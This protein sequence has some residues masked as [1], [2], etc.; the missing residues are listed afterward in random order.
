LRPKIQFI[1]SLNRYNVIIFFLLFGWMPAILFGQEQQNKDSLD[2]SLEEV[3]VTATRTKRQLSN[4]T[5]PVTIISKTEVQR[6]GAQRLSDLLEEQTGITTIP[7]FG[8]GIGVQLQGL[9]SQYTLILIDGQPL[10]GR[11]AGTLDLNRITVSNIEQIEVLKGASSSLYGNEALGGVINIITSKEV[12]QSSFRFDGRYATFNTSDIGLEFKHRFEDNLSITQSLNRYGSSGYRL[13]DQTTVATVQPF[14][15]YTYQ[16]NASFKKQKHEFQVNNRVFTQHQ[17]DALSNEIDGK[18]ETFEI[19]TLWKY[20]Y[21]PSEK[22]ELHTDLYRSNYKTE[23]LYTFSQS[24]ELYESNT[25]N[26]I[27]LRPEM[28]WISKPSD[29]TEYIV[30]VGYTYETLK[31]D[32]FFKEPIFKAPYILAQV[33]SDL[34][35]NT[36]LI[37]G[38]RFDSHNIY[39]SQLSPKLSFRHKIDPKTTLKGSIGYGFK[40]PDFRQL[41]FDFSNST[42][43]YIVLGHEAVQSRIPELIQSGQILNLLTDLEQFNDPLKAESSLGY[44][45]EISK[46]WSSTFKS[47]FNL[48][49]NEIQNLIDTKAIAR[50]TDG[51]N[52]FSY[53]NIDKVITQGVEANFVYRPSNF[54]S[55]STGGQYLIAKNRET[56]QEVK[57]GN[58]FVRPTPSSPAIRLQSTDYFGLFNRSRFMGNFKVFYEHPEGNWDSSFRAVYRSK[59]GL[60]DTNGNDFLDNYDEFVCGYAIIDVSVR[61]TISENFLVSLGF[62]N[63]LNY[64]DRDNIPNLPGRI[65]YLKLSIQL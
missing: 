13:N 31:R 20:V 38:L 65:S 49:R 1:M 55:I 63:V 3:V 21:K 53:F 27:F 47:T 9:D 12:E 35:V 56:T 42:I 16:T 2:I 62:D 57:E 50:K 39:N 33:D 17:N 32:Q 28:R 23:S 30:G 14:S 48:F 25:F 44:N 41:Y 15:N 18:V 46:K 8:G 45:L 61:K 10:I 11:A 40:A 59:Y 64:T 43:G 34:S 36:K 54:L 6:I 22:T 24:G 7:D 37:A 4:I 52:V 58:A 5:V 60:F 19:G 26:Q 51:Q 29:K